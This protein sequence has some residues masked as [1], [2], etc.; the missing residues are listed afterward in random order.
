MFK[1]FLAYVLEFISNIRFI[2]QLMMQ[3]SPMFF[4]LAAVMSLFSG[5]GSVFQA[6]L[7]QKIIDGIV[8]QIPFSTVFLYAATIISW[9]FISKLQQR[10][11]F[12]M[13]RVV[14]EELGVHMEN[15]LLEAMDDADPTVLDGLC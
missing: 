9:M 15:D 10:T 1:K 4:I 8:L 7:L 14:T 3:C 12:S 6:N 2:F 13:N 5:F 11:L